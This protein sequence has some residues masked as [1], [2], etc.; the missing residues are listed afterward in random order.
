[1]IKSIKKLNNVLQIV[2]FLLIIIFMNTNVEA[3]EYNFSCTNGMSVSS[4]PSEPQKLTVIVAG[5]PSCSN[6]ISTLKSIDNSDWIKEGIIKVIYADVDGITIENASKFAKNFSDSIYFS[7]GKFE[8]SC[9][10]CLPFI[11]Y[12]DS[13]GKI[14]RNSI[15]GYHSAREIYANYCEIFGYEIPRDKEEE[16]FQNK[17]QSDYSPEDYRGLPLFVYQADLYYNENIDYGDIIK[18]A[19]ELVIDCNSDLEKVKVIH[20]WIATNIAYDYENLYDANIAP[21]AEPAY[22]FQNKRGVC[23]GYARLARIMFGAV[24]IPCLNII[25][26]ADNGIDNSND[27]NHEWNAVWVE[28]KWGL[29][30][31]TW[32]SKNAYY[33]PNDPL[34]IIGELPRYDYFFPSD[35]KFELNHK[36]VEITGGIENSPIK[37]IIVSCEKTDYVIG[38]NLGNIDVKAVLANGNIVTWSEDV[39]FPIDISGYDKNKAG[40]QNI[41]V[42]ALGCTEELEIIVRESATTERINMSSGSTETHMT[43]EEKKPEMPVNTEEKGNIQNKTQDVV[44]SKSEKVTLADLKISNRSHTS[45]SIKFGCKNDS[46]ITGYIFEYSSKKDMSN[47]TVVFCNKNASDYYEIDGLTENTKYYYRIRAVKDKGGNREY[48]RWTE[49][50]TITTLQKIVEEK[51]VVPKVEIKSVKNKKKNSVY[52]KWKRKGGVDGFQIQFSKN[53]KFNNS[54]KKDYGSYEESACIKKFAK[55]KTYYFRIRSYIKDKYGLKKYSEWS[56]VKKIKVKR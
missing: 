38:E 29:M 24:G 6:T 14:V 30:D 56:N 52:V 1:M 55:G 53:K 22:V 51:I 10:G 17:L 42:K 28:D 3:E 20:D 31:I 19:E 9:S 4:V 36:S 18:K 41:I 44:E 34:N 47:S 27:I 37:K 43:T 25:G 8:T 23:S 46:N 26:I 2:V 54:K 5:R 45:Y 33:G 50:Y 39:F 12:I 49:I 11:F 15:D 21:S 13:S 32:D 35:F 16:E 40:K 48:S 7:Y